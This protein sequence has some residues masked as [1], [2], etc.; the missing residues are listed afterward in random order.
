MTGINTEPTEYPMPEPLTNAMVIA[1]ASAACDTVISAC[2][3]QQRA[4]FAY[5]DATT[6]DNRALY[7]RLV[8]VK[9]KRLLAAHAAY[10]AADHLYVTFLLGH[11]S[12]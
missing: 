1:L 4:A 3:D 11:L 9:T 6:P 10:K 12:E 2:A 8:R 7:K 5:R